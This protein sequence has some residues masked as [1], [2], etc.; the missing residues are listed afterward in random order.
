MVDDR[1]KYTIEKIIDFGGTGETI[2]QLKTG[3]VWMATYPESTD[4]EMIAVT[5]DI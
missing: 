4:F 2:Y 3:N 5:P 1:D